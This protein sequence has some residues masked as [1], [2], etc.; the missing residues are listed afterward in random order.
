MTGACLDVTARRRIEE[1]RD[2]ALESHCP[3]P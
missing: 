3:T 1:E 2:A